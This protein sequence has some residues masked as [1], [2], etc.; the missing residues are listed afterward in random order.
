MVTKTFFSSLAKNK[1]I[2]T[3][4]FK[5]LSGTPESFRGHHFASRDTF[6]DIYS[7]L[8]ETYASENQC[9]SMWNKVLEMAH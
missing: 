7:S 9:F 4:C 2:V 8:I 5:I 6:H 3:E 1:V